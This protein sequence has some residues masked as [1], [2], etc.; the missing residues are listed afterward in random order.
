MR[1][2]EHNCLQ[3]TEEA[4]GSESS[5]LVQKMFPLTQQQSLGQNPDVLI[6]SAFSHSRLLL[7]KEVLGQEVDQPIKPE[8][9]DSPYSHAKQICEGV[10]SQFYAYFVIRAG[11]IGNWHLFCFFPFRLGIIDLN[12]QC[13]SVVALFACI[14]KYDVLWPLFF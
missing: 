14:L 3:F 4:T 1:Q 9:S 8:R 2:S 6:Y 5:S 13:H 7:F 10:S 12:P 11:E